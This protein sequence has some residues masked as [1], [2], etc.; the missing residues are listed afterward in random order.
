MM[1]NINWVRDRFPALNDSTVHL[2]NPG[3]TQIV[4]DSLDRINDYLTHCNSNFHGAFESSRK[5]DEIILEARTGVAD[6]INASRPEEIVFGPNMTTLTFNISRSIARTWNKGDKIVVTRLE[7]DANITPWVIAAQ[8]RGCSVIY[9]DFHPEDCSLN[10]EEMKDAL[11]QNPVFVALGYASNAVGTINPVKKITLSAHKAGALVYIDAVQYAPHGPI[12]VQ[13]LGCD[14]LVFSAY[15][16]FGPHIGVLYG[17]YDLLDSLNAYK[18]RPASIYPPEKFETGTKNHEGIAGVLGVIEYLSQL[19]DMQNEEADISKGHSFKGR[20]LQLKKALYAIRAN[21][22]ELSRSIL[23]FLEEIPGLTLYGINDIR[24][25]EERV[26]TFAFALKDIH[27][28]VVAQKLDEFGIFVWDGNYYALSV[29]E[30]LGV[31]KD[32][33]LV[34]IGPVHYNTLGEITRLK[35]ALSEIAV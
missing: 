21:E 8:E 24:R 5:S 29:T 10:M 35:E 19:G 12:D 13:E 14:F 16:L 30:R 17:R 3:G 7:H 1:L 20:K 4:Q 6:L 26:P 18:V 22:Y 15:K 33:G 11:D 25:L 31:E 2:D 23:D 9:V 27:P 34:R 28:R 32:G